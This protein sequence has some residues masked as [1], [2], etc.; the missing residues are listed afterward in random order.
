HQIVGR[1]LETNLPCRF[2]ELKVL[3]GERQDRDFGQIDLLLPRERQKQVEWTLIAANVNDQ[4]LF[5]FGKLRRPARLKGQD[6]RRHAPAAHNRLTRASNSAFA[7]T[8]SK[9]NGGLRHANAASARSKALPDNSGVWRATSRI[10]SSLP[11]QCKTMSH[12]AAKM[13]WVRSA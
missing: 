5:T 10:S 6:L 1:K 7:A 13:A 3:I 11:L 12:P 4:R 8:R 2:Y 9:A